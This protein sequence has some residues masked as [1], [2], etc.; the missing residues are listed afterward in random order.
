MPLIDLWNTNP[1]A[2]AQLSIEQISSTAGNG[3]LLDN[4]TCSAELRQFLTEVSNK[5]LQEYAKA[6]LTS[7]FPKSGFVLQDLVNEIGRRLDYQV[8]NGRYHG[9][10]ADIGFDGIWRSSGARDLVVEVKTTDAYRIPLDTIASYRTRLQEAGQISSGASV[11]IVVGRED[12]GELEAQV[13]GS[14]HAWDMRLISIDAL[15][16]LVALK[17]STEAG[18]TGEKIR[19]ILVPMEFTRL[20]ALVDV[21]FATAKDVEATLESEDPPED[22]DDEEPVVGS[23]SRGWNFTDSGS[24]DEK[25]QQIIHAIGKQEGKTLIKRS[26]ALFWDSGHRFRLV[27][28]VSKRYS[29]KGATPYWY[30]Y[31][32]RWDEYLEGAE[33]AYFVLGCMDLNVAFAIPL[34]AL[35]GYLPAMNITKKDDGTYYWHIKILE[36][37]PNKY[38]LQLPKTGSLAS[39]VP[40]QLPLPASPPTPDTGAEQGLPIT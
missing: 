1:G 11:L 23:S 40:F 14:R 7:A 35:R 28:T 15:A 27:C 37:A 32:P 2:V 25:R 12:T 9:T 8:E 6:C 22:D 3:K 5:Q 34:D 30:A 29:K 18:L 36:P 10:K 39:L 19:S 21:L 33:T 31:H 20:D 26:R 17:E 24:L 16:T 38:A 4:S 13:R